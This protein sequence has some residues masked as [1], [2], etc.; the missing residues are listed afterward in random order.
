MCNNPTDRSISCPGRPMLS[1]PAP[2]TSFPPTT[3]ARLRPLGR[4]DGD[5]L[6]RILAGMSRESRYQRFHGPKPALGERDRAVLTDVDGR[7]H[8]ALVA[9]GADGAP[10]GVARAV[11]LAHDPAAA[12]LAAEVVDAAQGRGLGT[13]LVVA[14][15]RRAAAAGIERL[16]A[17][18]LVEGGLARRLQQRGWRVVGRD[19]AAVLLAVDVWAV[20]GERSPA[21][22]FSRPRTAR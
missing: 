9:L 14:L 20:A 19:G 3:A 6:D 7:D 16:T 8:L 4:G 21:G 22:R 10:L 17:R 12:E 11:R 2:A 13:E 1:S 15:A 5:L 18:V